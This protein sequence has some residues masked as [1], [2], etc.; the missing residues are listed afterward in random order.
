MH[1]P[2]S[3]VAQPEI[4]ADALFRATLQSMTHNAPIILIPKPNATAALV[5]RPRLF[6][7]AERRRCAKA[8]LA[9]AALVPQTGTVTV[10]I[11]GQDHTAMTSATQPRVVI[12]TTWGTRNMAT[13]GEFVRVTIAAVWATPAAPIMT[14]LNPFALVPVAPGF[15]VRIT[16]ALM[17]VH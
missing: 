3:Q 14:T 15:R 10:M 6:V 9:T 13:A 8:E 1:Q 4:Q 2:L 17:P 11:L 5:P 16:L 7:V 12:G